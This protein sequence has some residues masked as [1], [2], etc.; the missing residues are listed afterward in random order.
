VKDRI[1]KKRGR[2]RKT[3]PDAQ[4]CLEAAR[5]ILADV[6]AV[7]LVDVLDVLE[8]QVG[9]GEVGGAV[10]ALG[11]RCGRSNSEQIYALILGG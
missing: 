1:Q 10:L 8:V 9:G 4:D 6:W 7:V 3:T 2:V 5:A 11:P